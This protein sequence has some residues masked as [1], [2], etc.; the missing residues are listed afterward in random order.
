MHE[1]NI[2]DKDSLALSNI[3]S[4][5]YTS[6]G[7]NSLEKM[8]E[9]CLVKRAHPKLSHKIMLDICFPNLLRILDEKRSK[10]IWIIRTPAED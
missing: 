1:R 9:T 8:D 10:R 7:E 4:K 2:S 6:E 3:N 5:K